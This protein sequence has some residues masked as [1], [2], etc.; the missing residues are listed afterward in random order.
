[1][2]SFAKKTKKEASEKIKAEKDAIKDEFADVDTDD[3]RAQFVDELEEVL[4]NMEEK[5]SKIKSG[6]A[7]ADIFDDIQV[8]A[9]GEMMDFGDLC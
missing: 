2:R 9:Y 4:L 3:I 6:R 7:S 1:M 8:K 5:L